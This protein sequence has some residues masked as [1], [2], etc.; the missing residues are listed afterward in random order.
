V[1]ATRRDCGCQP[2][3]RPSLRR[4]RRI[5][6]GVGFGSTLLGILQDKLQLIEVE[7][8]RT[9]PLAVAQQ[10][11]DQLPQLFVLGL[12]FRH[13]F[14]HYPLQ[15]SRIVRQRREVGLHNAMMMH[16]VASRPM[17]PA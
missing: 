11:L 13:H 9:R 1:P 8:L 3:T 12:Q 6:G 2:C 4:F 14:L 10:T 17:T 5:F 16:A 15:D 7:L